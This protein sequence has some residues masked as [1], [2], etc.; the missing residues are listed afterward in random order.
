MIV[1]NH[2]QCSTELGREVPLEPKYSLQ[3]KMICCL[4]QKDQGRIQKIVL[5]KGTREFSTQTRSLAVFCLEFLPRNLDRTAPWAPWVLGIPPRPPQ[6]QR[7]VGSPENVFLSNWPYVFQCLVMQWQ[8]S[9]W[10]LQRHSNTYYGGPSFLFTAVSADL[11]HLSLASSALLSPFA[12]IL[13]WK[14]HHISKVGPPP[15]THP[16]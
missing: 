4:V 12:A 11:R 2:C 5:T 3:I 14:H 1:W 7:I 8:I 16:L 9:W 6:Y 13:Y 10:R 15:L